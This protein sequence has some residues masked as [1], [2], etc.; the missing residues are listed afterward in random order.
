MPLGL[1]EV[2]WEALGPQGLSGV[3]VDDAPL[4]SWLQWGFGVKGWGVTGGAWSM[5]LGGGVAQGVALKDNFQGLSQGFPM[6]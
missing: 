3:T 4:P 2:S 5:G 1:A 6:G